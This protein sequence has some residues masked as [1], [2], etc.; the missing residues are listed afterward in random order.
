MR[1]LIARWTPRL[2]RWE[3]PDAAA[4]STPVAGEDGQRHVLRSVSL[5]DAFDLPPLAR[6]RVRNL[7]IDDHR[8]QALRPV[9]PEALEVD[10]SGTRPPPSAEK[11]PDPA[12]PTTC[13]PRTRPGR[14]RWNVRTSR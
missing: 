9:T 13:G 12:V 2:A 3:R 14:A 1:N 6:A 7:L 5:P 4:P 8:A 10:S 11:R